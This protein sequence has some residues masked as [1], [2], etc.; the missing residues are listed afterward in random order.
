MQGNPTIDY[1]TEKF[2]IRNNPYWF[3]DFRCR[4]LKKQL[5]S[6]KKKKTGISAISNE[7][8]KNLSLSYI[9]KI[10]LLFNNIFKFSYFP[11]YWK[12]VIPTSILKSSKPSVLPTSYHFIFLL[13]SIRKLTEVYKLSK[14]SHT[15]IL[16]IKGIRYSLFSEN[17]FLRSTKWSDWWNILLPGK[18]L[19]FTAAVILVTVKEFDKV[20]IFCLIYKLINYNSPLTY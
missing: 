17:R 9:P 11:I 5:R 1:D 20:W 8:I 13:N 6:L 3:P 15:V 7:I 10:V 2:W 14:F 16:I 18:C 12:T 19:D 4:C